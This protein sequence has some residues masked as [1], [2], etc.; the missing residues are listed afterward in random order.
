MGCVDVNR[1]RRRGRHVCCEPANQIARFDER[2]SFCEQ[3]DG[4]AARLQAELQ[5]AR[6]AAER[7]GEEYVVVLPAGKVMAV[8][9]RF[10][11]GFG[12]RRP[13][14]RVH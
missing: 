14:N 2:G 10:L 3:G 5:E 6:R 8:P 7:A 9:V 11:Y 13:W 4:A 1:S 12:G